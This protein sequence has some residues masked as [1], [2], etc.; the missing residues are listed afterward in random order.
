MID[1]TSDV[2]F[3]LHG[4]LS[5]N[6]VCAFAIAAAL[7]SAMMS[8]T[9]NA[10]TTLDHVP[11]GTTQDGQAVDIYTMTNE[12]GLRVR[13]LSYGGVITEINTPNRVG[14]LDNIVLGLGTLR[15]YETLPGHFG[16][17]TG[18][19]ANRIGGAQ[20]TLNGQTYHLIA[21]NGPNTLHGGPN[22][23][24]HRVW[25]VSPLTT[26]NG[27]AAT[28]SYASPDGDQNFPGTLTTQVTYTLTNDDVLQIVYVASTDKD[29]VIN[30]T[31]HSYFNLAG[32]GS[33]SITDQLLVVNADRYTP[34]G[35]DQIPTGEIAP[36]EGTPL[37][38]RQMIPIGARLHSAFQQI[39]Y[40]RGYDHNFVLNKP[41]GG[42]MTFAARAY[43]PRSGRLIDCFT[44]E[45]GVQ[46]YTSN[47]MNGSIVGSSGTTYRQTEG[48][49]LET[50]HFPDS[51]NKPNF[52]ST[53]LKPGQ[54]FRST[55]IFRFAT[56]ASLPPLPR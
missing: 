38:F 26:P 31:N 37:D 22:A 46:V 50:Q 28:L 54:E 41:T 9:A 13:F 47:G 19:Y 3:R 36:V 21:N 48:F 39:V 25:T 35:P 53:E 45:P 44:S 11:Y 2:C 43:D 51:P 7:A 29:T 33:G 15:E 42:V 1:L 23:L 12:H 10:D 5:A 34:T 27:V 17:I 6:M 18:R 52:P 24:D 40:A 20:F 56:D 32:N 55:T 4:K 30:F 14:R 49:T 8:R 16:A